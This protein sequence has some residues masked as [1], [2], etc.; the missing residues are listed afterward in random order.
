[1]IKYIGEEIKVKQGFNNTFS[2]RHLSAHCTV[3]LSVQSL[4]ARLC[5]HLSFIRKFPCK[6]KVPHGQLP[7][8]ENSRKYLRELTLSVLHLPF[9]IYSK[10]LILSFPGVQTDLILHSKMHSNFTLTRGWSYYF[11]SNKI[12]TAFLP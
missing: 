6:G 12:I 11:F 1:M 7:I 4:S 9:K 3:P 2:F 5:L 8:K 10:S